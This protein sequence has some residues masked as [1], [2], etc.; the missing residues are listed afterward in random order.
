MCAS[1]IG[2]PV[3]SLFI[4]HCSCGL[5]PYA[6]IVLFYVDFLFPE[7]SYAFKYDHYSI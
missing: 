7:H 1:Y 2:W 3:I 6:A 4:V 5:T